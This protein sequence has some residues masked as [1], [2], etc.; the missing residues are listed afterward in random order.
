MSAFTACEG[1]EE[2]VARQSIPLF[3]FSMNLAGT[4]LRQT[5]CEPSQFYADSN[6]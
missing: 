3:R 1:A 5:S 4:V 2:T 6:A